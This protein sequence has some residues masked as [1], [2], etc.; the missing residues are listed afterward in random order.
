MTKYFIPLIAPENY[1]A[2]RRILHD[3]I[4]NSY[5]VWLDLRAKERTVLIG[6]GFDVVGVE[7][8][9]NEFTRYCDREGAKRDIHTL[10]GIVQMKGMR[11]ER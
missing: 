8:E 1:D 4:P 9:P 3:N 5:D 10:R 7:I 6:Q 11:E 2:F